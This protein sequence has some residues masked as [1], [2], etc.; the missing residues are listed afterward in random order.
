MGVPG[1]V[2]RSMFMMLTYSFP[3]REVSRALSNPPIWKGDIFKNTA[4][5]TVFWK[6]YP[7]SQ[8]VHQA[9]EYY[10]GYLGISKPGFE[11][12]LCYSLRNWPLWSTKQIYFTMTLQIRKFM[13]GNKNVSP[14][15]SRTHN[16]WKGQGGKK[17]SNV[18][19]TFDLLKKN[20]IKR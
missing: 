2:K 16:R 20:E 7:F 8:K 9:E 10:L 4:L 12:Q 18:C 13:T 5:Y 14:R 11:S 15:E 3:K 17:T 19:G 1:S 6:I